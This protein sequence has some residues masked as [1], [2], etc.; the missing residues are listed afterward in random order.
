MDLTAIAQLLQAFTSDVTDLLSV[1]VTGFKTFYLPA[2]PYFNIFNWPATGTIAGNATLPGQAM[3]L[4]LPWDLYVYGIARQSTGAFSFQIKGSGGGVFFQNAQVRSDTLWS[5]N[6]PVLWLRRP[7]KVAKY[8]SLTVDIT[9][10][11]GANNAGQI[12]LVGWKAAS[13]YSATQ[14]PATPAQ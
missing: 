5:A 1:I 10:V 14:A 7:F 13:Q 12:V 6:E 11:S 8:A 3:D 2:E 9:D 4:K